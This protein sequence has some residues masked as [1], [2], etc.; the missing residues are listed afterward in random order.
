M[1]YIAKSAARYFNGVS[2]QPFPVIV[3]LDA[4]QQQLLIE[5]EDETPIAVPFTHLKINHREKALLILGTKD[6]TR[7]TLEIRN[8]FFITAWFE[9]NKETGGG[10]W[11]H[12]LLRAGTIA[13]IALAVAVLAFCAS[14]YFFLV[15]WLAE[16]AVD[17]IPRTVD[18]RLGASYDDGAGMFEEKDSAC[19]VLLNKYL[20]TMAPEIDKRYRITVIDDDM[21]NAFAL[22]DGR[23]MVYTGILEKMKSQEELA[24]VLS[25]EISHV[26][27]R[28]SMRLMTRSLSG[29]LLLT[30]ML[31][32]VNGLMTIIV[33][34]AHNLQNLSYSRKFERQADLS[35]LELLR[36]HKINP[37]GMIRL[38]EMLNKEHDVEVP[39]WM[40]S[41]PVTT[42]RINYI[43]DEIKEHPYPSGEHPELKNIF[44]QIKTS[45]HE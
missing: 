19:S 44:N 4:I 13:H 14:L 45:L 36:R 22:P 21:V 6:A 40:S 26:E 33:D 28:H 15:P 16:Q 9:Y 3:Y 1:N 32:D 34:N 42:E 12:R 25:H 38:F 27:H 11:Y 41:H 39:G 31:N 18:D 24:G 37:Q 8:P 29:Y 17:L 7:R 35:G 2:A 23:L 5:S 43:R 10:M 20:H 30:L